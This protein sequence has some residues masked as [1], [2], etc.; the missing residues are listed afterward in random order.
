M[1][2]QLLTIHFW[3]FQNLSGLVKINI[4][5]WCN[6][7]QGDGTFLICAWCCPL[8]Q[9]LG[10]P[11]DYIKVIH[12]DILFRIAVFHCQRLSNR[13]ER[14]VELEASLT[15]NVSVSAALLSPNRPSKPPHSKPTVVCVHVCGG[16]RWDTDPI[17]LL[18]R[19]GCWVSKLLILRKQRCCWCSFPS[20][21]PVTLTQI[22]Y[23]WDTQSLDISFSPLVV[24]V[25]WTPNL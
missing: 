6:I 8:S 12:H 22:Q 15:A 5:W 11:S 14:C 10:L 4:I 1:Q 20:K 19:V 2:E 23:P 3:G 21:P 16:V 18:I 17:R 24:L 25:H 13:Q 7:V 9:W